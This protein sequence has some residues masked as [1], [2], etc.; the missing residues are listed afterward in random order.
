MGSVHPINNG[1]SFQSACIILV[2]K[3]LC[4][5]IM[6]WGFFT[7]VQEQ[8]YVIRNLLFS[9]NKMNLFLEADDVIYFIHVKSIMESR[10]DS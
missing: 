5:G 8:N 10:T 2:L 4:G 9:S 1:F 6:F 3:E 7:S